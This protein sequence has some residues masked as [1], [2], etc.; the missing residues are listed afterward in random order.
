MTGARRIFLYGSRARGDHAPRSDIDVAVNAPDLPEKAW[1]RIEDLAEEAETLYKIDCVWF[2][3]A[4]KTL[5]D[6]ILRDG[7]ILHER[8]A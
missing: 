7:K 1:D 5:S 6:N 3:N 4:P 8:P 2:Q